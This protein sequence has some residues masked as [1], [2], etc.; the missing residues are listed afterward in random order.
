MY[1]ECRYLTSGDKG[2]IIEVGN[3]ISEEINRKIRRLVFYIESS[4]FEEIIE[5]IPTY[6]SILLI[7][8]PLK[9]SY[10]NLLM[11]LRKIENSMKEMKLPSPEVIHIPTLYGGEYGLDLNYVAKYN[12]LTPEEVIKIHSER[13]YLVYMLGFT[14]GFP[15]L[16]G[17]SEKIATPRLRSPRE[18]ICSGAVGIA[19]KQTGIYPIDSPGG[20]Q[21]I[22]RT[23]V[24]LFDHNRDSAVLLSSGQYIRFEPIN[25]DEYRKISEEVERGVYK[26]R[27]SLLEGSDLDE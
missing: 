13:D 6:K 7:Y 5:L 12:G 18:K 24:K 25:V 1:K 23:P 3:E 26:V 19:G 20:W 9:I 22:G 11:K 2:I 17:M 4:D 16:G 21:L 10:K 8:D 15:Y 27:K 14:P